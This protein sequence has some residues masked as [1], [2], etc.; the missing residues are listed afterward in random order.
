V[1]LAGLEPFENLEFE[2]AR[3][4]G[5]REPYHAYAADALVALAQSRDGG[6]AAGYRIQV[7]VLIDHAALIRGWTNERHALSAAAPMLTDQTGGVP[8]HHVR[9]IRPG[10]IA[11][12]GARMAV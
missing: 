5:R 7:N 9:G 8:H 3:S 11:T 12:F 1:V 10:E 6:D 4:Q 2:A